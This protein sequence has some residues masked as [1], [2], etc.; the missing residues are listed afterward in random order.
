MKNTKF[1]LI[2]MNFLEFAIWGAYLTS[3]GRYLA[4]V[5]LADNI[6][7]FY[8]VQG[9]VSIFMPALMGILAD[10]WDA[11]KVLSLCHFLAGIAMIATGMY[12]LN[13][14]S[15]VQ[16]GT[17]FTLYTISVAFFMPTIALSYSVAYSVLEKAGMDTVTS[18]PPIRI[19]GTIG[20]II[21]MWSVDLA[22]FQATSAQY[23]VSGALSIVLALY[24]LSL[25]S[26]KVE[27]RIENNES[28]KNLAEAMGLKAFSL[29]KEKQ[30]AVFF[31]FS[32]LLGAALQISNGFA[33]PF[34]G[35]FEG[36]TAYANTF[37]VQHSNI[38][39]SLSQISETLC[40]LM[41]PFFLKKF[42]IKRVVLL[43]MF[44]WSLRFLFLGLGNPGEGVWLFILS[45]IVYGMAFDFFNI[46][47]SL[48]VD[49]NTSK[50]MR[51]SAQGLFMLMTNGLGA[52]IGSILAQALVTNFTS[53]LT[54]TEKMTGWS[55][56][57]FV[58]AAYAA[59]V[60]ILFAIFF[61]YK[62]K[63]EGA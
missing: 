15:N 19:W 26:C 35:D 53:G 7:W 4:S 33:N 60:G 31:I 12:G 11:K 62:H 5:G 45:M 17:L 6:G 41:I 56:A 38:L 46:S 61:N 24:A 20:F 34:L 39:V 3:Q 47:G 36:V 49:K 21:M 55:T 51:S 8:S 59:I 30:M 14:G 43:A 57:W 54:G 18:F 40:I 2:I 25:P 29:F 44:A 37:G 32:F 52:A 9:I 10:K 63:K 48:F 28:K 1:K 13:A 50:E 22:G 42:G 27:K 23:A 58:F 16:F